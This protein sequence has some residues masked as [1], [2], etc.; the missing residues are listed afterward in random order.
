M[1]KK[2]AKPQAAG[3]RKSAGDESACSKDGDW[4]D[5]VVAKLPPIITTDEALSLLRTSRRNFYRLVASGRLRTLK[6]AE[7][8][9][10]R[11]LIP[12][13]EFARYLRSLE[14]A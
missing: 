2:I 10:A 7:G 8:G 14:A 9:S 11:H 4:V 3:V 13:T 5:E 6:Q 12:R 1:V